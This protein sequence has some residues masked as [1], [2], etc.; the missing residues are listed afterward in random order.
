MIAPDDRPGGRRA[1]LGLWAVAGLLVVL[2][3]ATPTAFRAGGDNV[4]IVMAFTAG[5]L[6]LAAA[7]IAD[8]APP[9]QAMWLI[10]GVAVVLRLALLALE[11]LLSSD[12]YRYVWDGKV[13]ANGINPYRYIPA[14]PALAH[15]RDAAIYPNI[16]RVD[17]AVTIYPPVAQM[18]FLA[19]TR[20]GES[21]TAMKL[22][23]LACEAGTVV[24]ILLLLRRL[25]RPA[26][27]IVAYAWHPLPLWEIANNG[28][29][30]ALMVTLLM[31]GIW[32][33]V[34]RRPTL[35]GA[36]VTL[37]ALTKPYA[38]LALAALWKPWDWRI[39]LVAV[40]LVG[41]CYAPYLSVGWGVLGFLTRGYVTEESLDTGGTIWPLEVWR[42]VAG[43]LPGDYVVYLGLSALIIGSLAVW[44]VRRENAAPDELLGDIKRLLLAFLLLL[45][46]N[47]PWYFLA[48]TPFLALS[49]GGAVWAVTLGA[50]VF[51]EEVEWD[52]YIPVL[53]RKSVL[54]G[55]FIAVCLHAAWRLWHSRK[56]G[57]KR[58]RSYPG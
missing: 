54:Y 25:R 9:Q 46:P 34:L 32:F 20:I 48:L 24:F 52:R 4:Y 40:G 23:L 16:N 57:S 36:F 47:Y 31:A 10:L 22:A 43:T 18:F 53:T 27:R 56:G 55:M 14:D 35:G 45:S 42:L 51:H 19:A 33:A 1:L 49:G 11:P 39:P 58:E 5:L 29:I 2:T 3:L 30:D 28:H 15:L 38:V 13:Q 7:Q 26:Q 50:I 6:A 17:Y 8:R 21:V 41:L 44:S 37:A 12:I